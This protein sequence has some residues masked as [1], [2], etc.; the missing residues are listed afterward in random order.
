[1]QPESEVPPGLDTHLWQ[2]ADEVIFEHSPG[3]FAVANIIKTLGCFGAWKMCAGAQRVSMGRLRLPM[4]AAHQKS[5]SLQAS[6]LGGTHS[7]E[8]CSLTCGFDHNLFATRVLQYR[9]TGTA[10]RS[11][12]MQMS[13]RLQAAD[14]RQ[15]KG[16]AVSS[17]PGT[18]RHASIRDAGKVGIG[19]VPP[20]GIL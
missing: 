20:K 2:L 4:P 15:R 3:I 5:K 9:Y 19:T 1:M 17:D 10:R 13:T 12:R 16:S 14:S 7:H 11:H 6:T 18:Q 8:A